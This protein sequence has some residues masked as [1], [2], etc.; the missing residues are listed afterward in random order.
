MR[1]RSHLLIATALVIASCTSSNEP[2]LTTTT[3]SPMTTT[4]ATTLATST[5]SSTTTTVLQPEVSFPEYRIAERIISVET[6]DTV[7]LLLDPASYTSLSDLDLY[8]VI[9]DAVDR[10]PPIFEAHVVD[11]QDAVSAVL[12]EEQDEDQ[13]QMLEAHYLA[14]LEDGFRIVYLGTFAE[15]D[16]AVLGS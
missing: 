2:A 12:A 14:R 9:A 11:S 13:Q 6:G 7:V 15:S 8:D 4:T 1:S 10:F 3:T 16:D 5:T